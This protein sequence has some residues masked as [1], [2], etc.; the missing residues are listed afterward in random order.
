METALLALNLLLT[1][2]RL[3]EVKTDEKYLETTGWYSYKRLS[4]REGQIPKAIK[5]LKKLT[6]LEITDKS[7][8]A[9][10][11]SESSDETYTVKVLVEPL[12]YIDFY[13][14]CRWGEFRA[15]PC[16]HV[17][18]TTIYPLKDVLHIREELIVR[19]ESFIGY[20]DWDTYRIL[21]MV[22]TALNKAAYLRTRLGE[23]FA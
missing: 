9:E 5:L 11:P 1:A 21:T 14:N 2:R 17:L 8:I 7:I 22:H 6:V 13:C 3:Y 23:A 15:R 19:E 4:L 18:A 16:K 12:E 10:V 20:Q